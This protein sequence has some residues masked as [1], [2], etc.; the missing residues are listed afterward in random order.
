VSTGCNV[1]ATYEL[2]E[3]EYDVELVQQMVDAMGAALK[4][5]PPGKERVYLEEIVSD[6]Y[7][8]AE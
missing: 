1:F 6:I 2:Q 4:Q 7:P 5:F 3:N 8:W